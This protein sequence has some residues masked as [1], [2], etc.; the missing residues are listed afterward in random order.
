MK[1][2]ENSYIRRITLPSGKTIDVIYIDPPRELH[3]C[4]CCASRLVYPA[5]WAEVIPHGWNVTLRC[6]NCQWTQRAVY[7]QWNLER[8]DEELARGTETI[9]REPK[10]MAYVNMSE[11]IDRFVAALNSDHI[12]PEDF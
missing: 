4:P 12:L 11:E 6:P 2:D 5:E 10:R 9:A 7:T 1:R 8:F 3:V